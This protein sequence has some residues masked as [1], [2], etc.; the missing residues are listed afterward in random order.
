MLV[1]L[2]DL[3]E[4]R[5]FEQRI[6]ELNRD[7]RRT[8]LELEAATR[9][10]DRFI[11]NASHELRT[12]LQSVIGYTQRLLF[13]RVG[14]LQQGAARRARDRRALGAPPAGGHRVA[15]RHRAARVGRA[16][17]STRTRFDPHVTV[18]QV[19]DTLEPLASVKGLELRRA[20]TTGPA[21]IESDETK[22]RQILLNLVGQRR[23]VHRRRDRSR[24]D[25]AHEGEAA[26][27]V[28]RARHRSR[29]P[30]ER[31]SSASSRRS[32]ACATRQSAERRCRAS[33]CTS[34]RFWSG[35]LGG[36]DRGGER[37]R[38]RA[39]RSP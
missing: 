25:C 27:R 29:H 8:V 35:M 20:Y 30:A 33:G 31:S 1:L 6:V 13:E 4:K 12:P 17:R 36:Y 24:V 15:A 19:L 32:T 26:R 16:R 10:K 37:C 2:T 5:A 28:P 11:A 23:E 22:V 21:E 34:R 9:A 39:R 18:R 14:P 3:A 7:L 38:A